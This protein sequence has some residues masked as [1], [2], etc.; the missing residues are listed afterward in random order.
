MPKVMA[1][2]YFYGVSFFY[3]QFISNSI[4]SLLFP[5]RK[6]KVLKHHIPHRILLK[7]G[8]YSWLGWKEICLLSISKVWGNAINILHT[9][10]TYIS[11]E[12]STLNINR[13]FFQMK[14]PIF[15]RPQLKT[16]SNKTGRREPKCLS[17]KV[18]DHP[19][20][21]QIWLLPLYY[22]DSSPPPKRAGLCPTA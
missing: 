9:F 16:E 4:A 13:F 20:A 12:P 21:V 3:F 10:P 6:K 15:P 11:Q 19:Q 22:I 18:Y 8:G 2:S 17:Q 7:P 5:F 14:E 1:I